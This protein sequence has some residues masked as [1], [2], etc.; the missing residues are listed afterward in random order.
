MKLRYRVWALPTVAFGLCLSTGCGPTN[1]EALTGESKVAPHKEG[2]PDF[3][4]YSEAMTY[5]KEQAAKNKS[6]KGAAKKT[7]AE[8][9]PAEGAAT[10]AD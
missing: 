10:K 9:K 4:S 6:V 3:K 2:T 5:Q 1:E 7:Q 8:P